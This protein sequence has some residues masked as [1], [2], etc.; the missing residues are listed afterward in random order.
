MYVFYSHKKSILTIQRLLK[1][2]LT[3]KQVLLKEHDCEKYQYSSR[4]NITYLFICY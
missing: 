1:K 4:W 3:L 2:K